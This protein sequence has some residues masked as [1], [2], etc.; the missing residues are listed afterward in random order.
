MKRRKVKRYRKS[1]KEQDAMDAMILR[2]LEKIRAGINNAWDV[3]SGPLSAPFTD[4]AHSMTNPF[5]NKHGS[6]EE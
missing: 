3:F 6:H 2:D 1:Q 4:I 5:I